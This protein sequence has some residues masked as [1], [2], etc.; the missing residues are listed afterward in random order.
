MLGR[1]CWRR[2]GVLN[3]AGSA[4]RGWECWKELG[5]L[6]GAGTAGV[7]EVLG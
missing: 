2:L 6:K 1:D 3:E 5:V 4:G 7:L